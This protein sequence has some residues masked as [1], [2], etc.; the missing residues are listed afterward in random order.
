MTFLQLFIVGMASFLVGVTAMGYLCFVWINYN[1]S[2]LGAILKGFMLTIGTS[3]GIKT[4]VLRDEDDSMCIIR[5]EHIAE[6]LERRITLGIYDKRQTNENE[7][8]LRHE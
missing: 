4:L 2:R 1:P 3:L 7:R 5:I 8:D 6:V